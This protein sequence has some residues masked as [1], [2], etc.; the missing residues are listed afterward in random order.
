MSDALY[1]MHREKLEKAEIVRIK[2][3]LQSDWFSNGQSA[4]KNPESEE[5]RI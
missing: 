3:Q 2:E 1:E 4:V 5:L